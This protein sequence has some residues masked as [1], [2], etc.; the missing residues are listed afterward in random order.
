[1]K[2]QRNQPDRHRPVSYRRSPGSTLL[3]F[4]YSF[5]SLLWLLVPVWLTPSCNGNMGP[6]LHPGDEVFVQPDSCLYSVVLVEQ[7]NSS[8]TTR[9]VRRL[10]LFVYDADGLH[11]LLLQRQYGFLPDSV[12]LYGPAT[13][14]TVVAVANSPRDFNAGALERYDSIELLRYDYLED[15][16]AQPIMGG[17]CNVTDGARATLVLSPLLCRVA[18]GE[19]SNELQ[20]YTRL[21]DPRVYLEN[22]NASAELLRTV[23]FLPTETVPDPPRVKLPYDIGIFTQ[24]PGSELFCYPNDSAQ[25]TIGSPSTALVFECEIK[26]ATRQFR[27]PLPGLKR[28]TTTHVDI[29]ITVLGDL[30]YNV[31]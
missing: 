9:R 8:D 30:E 2:S 16:P 24:S 6:D 22:M 5:F 17:Q 31:Y 15:S 10:D 25:A 20:G 1:M 7:D 3:H 14:V 26:G 12:V 21:E 13:G 4:S 19:V 11:S 18:L 27:V 23:G 28:N 29:S